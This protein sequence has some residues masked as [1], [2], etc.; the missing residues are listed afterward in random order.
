MFTNQ[1]IEN[2]IEMVGYSGSRADA[3]RIYRKEVD[4]EAWGQAYEEYPE[5]NHN[6]KHTRAAVRM[7]MGSMK[8]K[9][10]AES[11]GEWDAIEYHLKGMIEGGLT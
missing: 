8:D 4:S 11:N 9:Y 10:G 6:F 1:E 7:I 3:F 5:Y 2:L